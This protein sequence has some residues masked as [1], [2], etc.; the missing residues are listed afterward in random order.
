MTT[1]ESD[2]KMPL[3]LKCFLVV[4]VLSAILVPCFFL[5]GHWLGYRF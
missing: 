3:E 1:D 5:I 4:S 2:E